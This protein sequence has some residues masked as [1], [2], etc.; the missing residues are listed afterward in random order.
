MTAG[1]IHSEVRAYYD[2]R[3]RAAGPTPA[4]V[5][6]NS[7]T[8]QDLRFRQLLRCWHIEESSSILDYG[9]GY[10]ALLDY[11]DLSGV[12]AAYTGFDISAS[13]IGEAERLHAPSRDCHFTSA[14][15]TLPESDYVVASGIF[16][17]RQA[18]ADHEWQRY[19]EEEVMR[20]AE[21]ARIGIAYNVLSTYS[22]P[23][24]RRDYLYYADPLTWF[25]FCKRNVGNSVALLHDYPLYE[26]TLVTS[27][28]G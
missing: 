14:P 22:D 4:G 12:R 3:L 21:L 11:L 25:D 26:F 28:G 15:E 7:A 5:D 17:V 8:S 27:K 19:M 20:M 10:G 16:N 9:C 2:A 6:W 13:M 23:E 18:T 24:K 1:N